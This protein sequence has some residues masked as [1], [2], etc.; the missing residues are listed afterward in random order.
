MTLPMP[1][2]RGF[3]R[4]LALAEHAG[5]GATIVDMDVSRPEPLTG[6][7]WFSL[8]VSSLTWRTS[9]HSRE[10]EVVKAASG[11]RIEAITLLWFSAR[12]YATDANADALATQAALYIP[13]PEGRALRRYS[14]NSRTGRRLP[15]ETSVTPS[16]TISRPSALTSEVNTPEL[17]LPVLRAISLPLSR[18]S[19]TRT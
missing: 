11:K 2:G 9:H 7:V 12:P 19:L 17:W 6:F 15:A 1:N 5:R 8:G 10:P 18:S 13:M 16:G 14:V 4:T 3:C